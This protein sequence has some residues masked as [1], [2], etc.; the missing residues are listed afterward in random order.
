ML[1]EQSDDVESEAE[2]PEIEA[3]KLEKAAAKAKAKELK[4]KAA[5]TSKP[6]VLN[7]VHPLDFEIE[8]VI[9]DRIREPEEKKPKV[10]KE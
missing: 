7:E 3:E 9:A 1:A 10:Q 6:I 4:V 5:A 2:Q 8:C